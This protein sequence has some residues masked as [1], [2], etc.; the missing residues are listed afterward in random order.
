MLEKSWLNLIRSYLSLLKQT[1][2]KELE[3]VNEKLK[4]EIER[5]KT[6]S[7]AYRWVLIFPTY[8]LKDI[9]SC[10]HF[11]CL[12]ESIWV[13]SNEG[14]TQYFFWL[15][16]PWSCALLVRTYMYKMQELLCFCFNSF[17]IWYNVSRTDIVL[18]ILRV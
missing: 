12:C 10:S 18:Y 13:Y 4:N 15:F 1:R 7:D 2:I 5:L 9:L 16:I 14:Q 8:Y 3:K 17:Q 6:T 11:L